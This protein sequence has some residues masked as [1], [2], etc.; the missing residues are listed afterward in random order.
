MATATGRRADVDIKEIRMRKITMLLACAVAILALAV[1]PAFAQNA[2]E[3]TYEGLAGAQQGGGDGAVQASDSG[4]SLPFTGL[5]LV[6]VAGAGAGLLGA[7]YA[8]RRA[9]QLRESAS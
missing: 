7:G 3:N 9:S 2:T 8:V 5:Q 4:G 6:L 1:A